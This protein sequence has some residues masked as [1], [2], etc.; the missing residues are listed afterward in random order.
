MAATDWRG[1]GGGGGGTADSQTVRQTSTDTDRRADALGHTAGVGSVHALLMWCL[2]CSSREV[3]RR[4]RLTYAMLCFAVFF[5]CGAERDN[6][7]QFAP[8]S[9][10]TSCYS[11]AHGVE[12][13]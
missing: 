1:G 3:N 9:E 10:C 8:A 7:P 4:R 6:I 5:S 2:M 13:Q 12:R 11:K